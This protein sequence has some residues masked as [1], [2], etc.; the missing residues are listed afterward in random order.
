MFRKYKKAREELLAATDSATK[1]NKE[2]ERCKKELTKLYNLIQHAEKTGKVLILSELD[3]IDLCKKIS[4]EGVDVE[5]IT[6]N[7][8]ILRL[9]KKD[10]NLYDNWK[11]PFT[12][13]G[14]AT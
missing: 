4:E 10:T 1:L 14:D 9:S 7:N 8:D 2:M 12:M 5:L 11:D 13:I 6:A 3:T